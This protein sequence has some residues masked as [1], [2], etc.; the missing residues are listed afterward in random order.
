MAGQSQR[1]FDAGYLLPKSLIQIFEKTMIGHILEFFKD[2]KDV[3]IVVNKKDYELY[4][5]ESIIRKCHNTARIL[6]IEPH[7]FGPSYTIRMV[8]DYI[9]LNKK[10][11]V[12]YCDVLGEWDIKETLNLLDSNSGV[13]LCFKGYHPSTVNKTTYAYVRSNEANEVLEIKEKAS[14]TNT[15]DAEYASGGIYA[16]TSGEVLLTAI[17]TMIAKSRSTNGEYYVSIGQQMMIEKHEKIKIQEMNKFYA[18]GKPE[19]LEDFM[20][21]QNIFRLIKLCDEN[22][23]PI[24]DHNGIVLAAGKSSRLRILGSIS[25]QS[26]IILKKSLLDYSFMLIKNTNQKFLVATEQTYP[27]NYLDLPP[28]NQSIL[29]HPTESQLS[30]AKLGLALN[31]S[32]DLPVTFLSSD[33][34]IVF[35]D[36]ESLIDLTSQYDVCVWTS[37]NYSIARNNPEQYSWVKINDENLIEDFLFK[38]NPID[39]RNWRLVTG[40]FSFKNKLLVENLISKLEVSFNVLL[41]EPMLDDLIRIALDLQLRIVSFDVKNYLTLGSISEDQMFEYWKN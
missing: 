21:Y 26:K 27:A 10:C 4:D 22:L 33:N 14:F 16:F 1:F 41:R 25:K 19:D 20:Y 32:R 29:S 9:A 28:L 7:N 12:H 35:N 31:M 15:P 39:F 2:Y 18:W 11:I 5:F 38:S 23:T 30:S 13:M 40:N 24:V 3:I 34:I 17:K 6:I 37:N 36:A 8:E